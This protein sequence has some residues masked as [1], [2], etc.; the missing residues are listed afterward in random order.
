MEKFEKLFLFRQSSLDDN[1]YFIY[2]KRFLFFKQLVATFEMYPE[3]MDSDLQ[4]IKD[5]T[6]AECSAIQEK[7]D[8]LIL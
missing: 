7:C 5:L 6:D 3:K 4:F 1:V 8:D 2:K